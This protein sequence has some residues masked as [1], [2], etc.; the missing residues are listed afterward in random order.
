MLTIDGL[1]AY[2]GKSHVLQGVSLTVDEGEIVCLL[3]RNGAGKTTTLKSIV[4][5]VP[6]RTGRISFGDRRIETLRTYEIARLGVALVPEQRGI[7][8]LLTVE[9]NLAIAARTASQWNLAAIYRM[10][11]RLEERRRNRGTA[12]SGGEQQMLA[13]ARA[14]IGGPRLLLLDEPTEGLAPVIVEELMTI[15]GEVRRAGVSVLLVEQ[16]LKF[17]EALADRHYILDQGSIV[18][19]SD[20][21]GFVSA[22]AERERYLAVA[23][24]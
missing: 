5:A 6:T 3:G 1:N 15:V 24:Y 22:H 13:I 16:N 2:Y 8:G 20:R 14:L 7:F 9:E 19:T 17:C 10:F 23:A 12:L 21:A 11:P 4:G 18:F